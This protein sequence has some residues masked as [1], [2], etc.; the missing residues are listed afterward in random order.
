M[1]DVLTWVLIAL[2]IPFLIV[3]VR[4]TVRRAKA[5]S[6]RIDEYHR[7]QEAAKQR[8]GPVNPYQDMAQA[9]GVEPPPEEKREDGQ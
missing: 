6:D 2:S 3:V 5:L 9:F 1:T 8:P 4:L 7:E